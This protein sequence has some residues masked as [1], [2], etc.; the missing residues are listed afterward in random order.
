MQFELQEVVMA[1]RALGDLEGDI[2]TLTGRI[3]TDSR[4]VEK[5]DFFVCLSGD[6]FDGHNFAREAVQRGAAAV[7]AHK[8]LPE[9]DK[10]PVFMVRDTLSALGDLAAFARH[11]TGARVIAVTG[12]AGKT[13]TKELL[14]AVL[15]NAGKTGRNYK[16]Y[17]NQV[18][19]PLSIFAMRGD[20]DFWILELGIN[21]PEDMD[22]LGRI[23]GADIAV[24]V[25]IGPCHLEGLVD[26]KGVARSK[27]VLLDYMSPDGFCVAA[28]D[29]PQLVEEIDLRRELE[30]F[31]FGSESGFCRAE[32]L[33]ERDNQGL[34]RLLIRDREYEL[35]LPFLGE[36]LAESVAAAACAALAAGVPAEEIAP[37]MTGVEVPE[38]R[39]R[40]KSIGN[41]FV[42]D[43]SYNANPLSM[44]GAIQAAREAAGNEELVLVLGEM[45]ELGEKRADQH[46]NLGAWISESGCTKAYFAGPSHKDV[47]AGIDPQRRNV[48]QPVRS[49]EDFVR[50]WKDCGHEKGTVLFKGSR[51]AGMEKY[52]HGLDAASGFNPGRNRD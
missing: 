28:A 29:Y 15:K 19:L 25:N 13:T 7:I 32:Y 47:L 3:R 4:A 48:F 41:W 5:G 26:E 45:G 43:D 8:P 44:R 18:G 36:H 37:G 10:A 27:C 31:W 2:A 46:R 9:I 51:S 24:I 21:R 34:Y 42:L 50:K 22:D 14:Y 1:M 52:M 33:G 30:K 6:N 11:R 17:N 23:A 40:S 20:E 38:H 12:S 16:N 49:P 39:M 35:L